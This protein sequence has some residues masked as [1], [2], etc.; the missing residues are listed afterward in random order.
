[1][2]NG[3]AKATGFHDDGATC[4]DVFQLPRGRALLP[5]G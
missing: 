3:D 1:M 2:C 5:D 4:V